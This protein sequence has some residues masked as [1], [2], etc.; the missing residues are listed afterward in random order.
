MGRVG[1]VLL[2]VESDEPM[3]ELALLADW[4]RQE[5]DLRGLVTVPRDAPRP[6]ELGS[7]TEVLAVAVGSGGTLSVLAAS[8]Q[9]F[10]TVRRRATTR[11]TVR[12]TPDERT[13]TL[14]TRNAADAVELLRE[15][16]GQDE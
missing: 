1:D 6:G 12:V 7:A 2:T 3:D 10:L 4:L 15:L 5:P 9:T 16:R 11:V 14:D 13:I 8:L